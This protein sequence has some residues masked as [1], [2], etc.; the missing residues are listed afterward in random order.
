MS[1]LNDFLKK[2]SSDS[3]AL[4]NFRDDPEK[5][6]DEAGLSAE[7]KDTVLSEDPARIRAALQPDPNNMLAS[8]VVVVVV[9][10]IR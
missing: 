6:M 9:A 1:A 2:L 7:D 10:V 8:V 3:K 4:K 5:S